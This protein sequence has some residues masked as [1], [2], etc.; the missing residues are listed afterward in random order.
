MTDTLTVIGTIGTDPRSIDTAS[1]TAMTSFRLATAQ[2][3]YDRAEQRWIDVSTNWYTVTAFNGLAGNALSSLARGDRV[4]VTGRLGV[5]VWEA[6]GK[7]GTDVIITAEG[8]G[9]DLAWGTTRYTKT[10]VR[11]AAPAA[12]ASEP[13]WSEQAPGEGLAPKDWGAAPDGSGAVRAADGSRAAVG[14]DGDAPLLSVGSG[15]T[16]F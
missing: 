16:P 12:P 3:R 4:L 5:K 6:G 15:D 8:I 9:H 10:L 1:G 7:T 11:A 2:R 14:L 13:A